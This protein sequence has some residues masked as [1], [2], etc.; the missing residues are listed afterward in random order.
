MTKDTVHAAVAVTIN[1]D[2]Q[3]FR[4]TVKAIQVECGTGN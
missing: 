2:F 4:D 1:G 3:Y